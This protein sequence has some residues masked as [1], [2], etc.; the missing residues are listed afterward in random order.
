[1]VGE[2]LVERS[3][4]ATKLALS[5]QEKLDVLKLLNSGF[6]DLVDADHVADEIEQSD[7]FKDVHAVVVQIDRILKTADRHDIPLY[8]LVWDLFKQ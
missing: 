8:H 3:P 5:L 6:I 2:L 1:M 4:D 7:Q